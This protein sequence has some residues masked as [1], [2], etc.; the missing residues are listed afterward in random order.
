MFARKSKRSSLK[1]AIKMISIFFIA[2]VF[3][4]LYYGY[5]LKIIAPTKSLLIPRYT[6]WYLLTIATL[7]LCES[8]FKK[9]KFKFIFIVSMIIALSF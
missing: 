5:I 4:T 8:I 2:Q 6:L 1:R 7:Y 9:Y 3:I